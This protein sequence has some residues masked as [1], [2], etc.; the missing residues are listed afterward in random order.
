MNCL[1]IPAAGKS[2]RFP[3][4][5]LKWLLTHPT[6]ELVLEKVLKTFNFENYDR[7]I[8]SVL[9]SHEEKYSI[10]TILDQIKW[11]D[12]LELCI[13]ESPTDSSVETIFQ[14]IQKMEIEGHITIKDSDGVIE[15]VFPTDTNYVCGCNISDFNVRD[16]SNKSFIVHNENYAILDIQEKKVISDVICL[17]AYSMGVKDFLFAY[18]S[19]SN[20][21][22]YRY[23]TEMYVSHI[24]SYLLSHKRS[25]QCQ[26]VDSF[27]DWGTLEAWRREQSK[28]KTYFL[29]IDGVF[30]ENTG[31][32]GTKNWS[33]T[34]E[35][36]LENI[37]WLK[38]LSDSGAE[39]IFTTSRTE[40]Y[41]TNFIS[42]LH[43]HGI[44]YKT[45][46]SGCNHSQRIVIN[47][48]AKTNPYPSCKSLS[49]PRNAKIKDYLE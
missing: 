27:S 22:A 17:G 3:D 30:L 37:D 28:Y 14:T 26:Y 41:L 38:A 16:V 20:S 8:L 1:I 32:Y 11:L 33:N 35:P 2:S 15:G 36:I 25:F 47:D 12:R 29:D 44:K 23:N 6:G 7:I 18:E 5:K 45:I 4:M 48:F 39:I 43:N 34:F 10:S 9:R 24:V 40:E 19:I 31:K 46:I 49:I 13:L 42:F 21:L